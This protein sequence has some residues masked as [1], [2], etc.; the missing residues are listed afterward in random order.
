VVG[1]WS[2]V[3]ATNLHRVEYPTLPVKW[4]NLAGKAVRLAASLL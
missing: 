3:S 4:W 2:I 1:I